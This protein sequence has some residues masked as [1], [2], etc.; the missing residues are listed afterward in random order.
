MANNFQ[1]DGTVQTLERII[2]GHRG[3]YV[4]VTYRYSLLRQV[5]EPIR[6]SV[7]ET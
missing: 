2:I 3:L 4:A 1:F 7:L 5:L 6:N